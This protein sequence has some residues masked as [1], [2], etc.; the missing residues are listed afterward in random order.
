M[1][2]RQSDIYAA[3]ESERAYQDALWKDSEH[4]E[5]SNPLTIGE[6]ILL[7]EEY[8]M[9]ARKEWSE[10]P[11]PEIA[12]LNTIRKIAGIA[13]NCMEQHGAPQREGFER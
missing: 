4:P 1:T 5:H 2:T 12:A 10:E 3:I 9:K 6:F 11:K 7:I 13:V 8:A